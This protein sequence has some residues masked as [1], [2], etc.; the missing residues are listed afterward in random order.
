MDN[1]NEVATAGKTS[2]HIEGKDIHDIPSF[3]CEINRV[4]MSNE[5]WQIGNSLDAFNDL[6]YGGF[7][8]LD[9]T[10]ETDIVWKDIEFSRKA[11]GY[12]E[13]KLFYLQKLVPGSPYNI[14]YHQEKLKELES[15]KGQTFFDIVLEIIADH[16]RLNLI[17]R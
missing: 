12:E 16:P 3:Y 7:G 14:S 11:L 6:L 10:M 2:I 17:A 9:P 13:T 8:V 15:G 4:L 5:V 1:Q